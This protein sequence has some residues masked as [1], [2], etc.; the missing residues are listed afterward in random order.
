MKII[1]E[2]RGGIVQAV[3]SDDPRETG[4]QV[5]DHDNILAGEHPPVDYMFPVD[6]VADFKPR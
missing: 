5:Y 2:V 4:V 3:Y 1:V 6:H